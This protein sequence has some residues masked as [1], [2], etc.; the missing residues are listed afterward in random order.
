MSQSEKPTLG[1]KIDL[2]LTAMANQ[3]NG[4]IERFE[5]MQQTSLAYALE[6]SDDAFEAAATIKTVAI[7]REMLHSLS[8]AA[9]LRRLGEQVQRGAMYPDK[10]TSATSRLLKLYE[11]K[12]QARCFEMVEAHIAAQ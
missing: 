3:A 1:E 7:V 6:C 11:V 9:V 5:S 12:A 8:P 4:V 10:S 2:S